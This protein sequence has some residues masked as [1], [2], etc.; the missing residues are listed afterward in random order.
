M[1][2]KTMRCA[3]QGFFFGEVSMIHWMQSFYRAR[4]YISNVLR[5]SHMQDLHV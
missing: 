5:R 1:S 3:D 4:A 2:S